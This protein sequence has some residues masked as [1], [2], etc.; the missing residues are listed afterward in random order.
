MSDII[1][2][3]ESIT[4]GYSQISVLKNVSFSLE[5]GEMGVIL[6]ASGCGKTTLLRIIAGLEK[7]HEGQ[8]IIEGKVVSSSRE[9][10]IPQRRKVGYVFQDYA[11]F[12]HLTV[13]QNITFGIQNSE[14]KIKILNQML[15]LFK[16]E[17]KKDQFPH[18]LSGGQQQRV[19]IARSLAVAPEILLMD[20]P[21]SNL[22]LKMREELIQELGT[23]FKEL[24]TSCLIVT[25][26]IGEAFSFADKMGVLIDGELLQWE[27]PKKIFFNPS[28]K[29]IVEVLQSGNLFAGEFAQNKIKTILGDF[30]VRQTNLKV[31]EGQRC[32]LFLPHGAIK[33]NNSGSYNGNLKHYRF[34]GKS[35][36]CHIEYAPNC[37]FSIIESADFDVKPNSSIRFAINND[38]AVI[39]PIE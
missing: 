10:V 14:S 18:Q 30:D 5:K 12:P 7:K 11:L 28:T 37:Y 17:N 15:A 13:G 26:E 35:N 8:I 19:A 1:L 2:N 38:L 16:L 6:G 29:K 9:F 31:A 25:H 36:L 34:N 3:C 32:N 33:I 21:F 23:I 20:E 24:K 27:T 4:F 22:D 39:L